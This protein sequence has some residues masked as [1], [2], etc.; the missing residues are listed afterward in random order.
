MNWSLLKGILISLIFGIA[1][2]PK[3]EQSNVPI[4][5]SFRLDNDFDTLLFQEDIQNITRLGI[6]NIGVEYII[7]ND[8]SNLPFIQN[9]L[10]I[11][12]VLDYLQ[13]QNLK[14][15]IILTKWNQEDIKVP[16][17]LLTDWNVHYQKLIQKTLWSV[18]PYKIIQSF[19]Y[20][21]DFD[22]IEHQTSIYQSFIPDIQ[23]NYDFPIFYSSLL[24]KTQDCILHQ[25]SNTVGIFYEHEPSD[26][27][28][29][30]ARRLHPVLSKLYKSKKIFITHANLQGDNAKLQFQ[31]LL[32][33][34][35]LKNLFLIN[36]NSIYGQSVVSRDSIYFSLKRNE[37]FLN[38]IQEYCQ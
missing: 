12:Y 7:K 10:S 26:K 4:A 15:H 9:A 23:K 24:N 2:N 27:H 6:K 16:D 36:I 28:K 13:N 32:R 33:F 14:V 37:D 22:N 38:Y 25:F 11:K 18:K 19:V 20:A 29:K 1:C 30:L 31:N 34:W 3:L 21:V 8:S 5:F 35:E 17:S